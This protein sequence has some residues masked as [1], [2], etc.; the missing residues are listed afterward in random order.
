MRHFSP[1]QLNTYLVEGNRPLLI[2]VREPWEFKI[3]HLEGSELLPMRQIPYQLDNF[4]Q[5]QEMVIIC[6]HGIRSRQV[7][8]FLENAGFTKII[9]LQGG[10]AAW[11]Q[12]VD[13]NMPV[14]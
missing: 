11:A 3:C 10:L 4:D 8:R 13:P 12:E 9:N 2:D 5:T 1:S 14:Y 6:H 7:G